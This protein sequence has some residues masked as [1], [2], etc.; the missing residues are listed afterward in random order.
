MGKKAEKLQEVEGNEA[1]QAMLEKTEKL[2]EDPTKLQE[3]EEVY[4][5]TQKQR[6]LC[7]LL[8]IGPDLMQIY[9][10]NHTNYSATVKLQT[11]PSATSPSSATSSTRQ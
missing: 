10:V 11:S 8:D 2:A 3:P 1:L 5:M 9:V 6:G 7:R 4:R